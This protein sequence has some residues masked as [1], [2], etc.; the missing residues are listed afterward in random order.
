VLGALLGLTIASAGLIS[1]WPAARALRFSIDT[2]LRQGTPQQGIGKAQHRMRAMFVVAEI[3][4]SLTLLVGCGLLLRTIYALKHVQLGFRTEHILVANM[5]IPSYKFAGRDMTTALYQPLVDR[6][7]HLQGVES[8]TLLTEVPLGKT[9]Q[10][11]FTFAP[12]G[13]SA[14]DLRRS[15]LQ[16][17]FRAVGPE[18]QRVFGFQMLRGRFFNEG[19]TPTSQAAVVVNRAF[20]KAY[21]GD[22]RDP[23]RILG[24]SLIGFGKERRSV[25]V[26]VVDDERQVSVAEPSQPE[27]EVCIPQITPESMFYKAAEGMSMD[28]AVRTARSPSL[29]APELR[30]AMRVGS[31][32]LAASSITTMDQIV[33]DSFGS[34]N[35]AAELLMIFGGAALLLCLTGIYGLL[36]YMAAQRRREMGLRIALGAQRWDVMGLILRQAVWMLVA[37]LALGLGVAFMASK[38]LR[39]LLYEVKAD[40]PLTM[41]AVALVLFVGGI[42]ASMV[43]ARTVTRVD[44][45]ETLRAE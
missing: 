22:D 17:Q 28:L 9:F 6:V 8:A 14:D 24:E 23:A 18:M 19:D 29:V 38:A 33:E 45:M 3:A 7:K 10:M 1:I 12:G 25:V 44:P 13:N 36:A 21:Y 37:G 40:D 42:A 27:M 32:D 11:M 31:S 5:T 43:P 26:G 16:A 39:T 30:D 41:G 15:S 20:V 35:L 34:Q 4:L 2:T